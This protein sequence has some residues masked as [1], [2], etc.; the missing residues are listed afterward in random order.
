MNFIRR[1]L[2]AK[3]ES[4]KDQFRTWQDPDHEE[5]P[6]VCDKIELEGIDPA[7][8]GKLL[9]QAIAADAEFIG[10]TVYFQ[11]VRLAW[12]YDEPSQTLHITCTKKPFYASCELVEKHIRELVAKA[13]ESV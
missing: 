3:V 10:L 8:Y 2:K 9:H 1:L 13:Q 6:T 5:V 11:G 7:L 12:N 4:T